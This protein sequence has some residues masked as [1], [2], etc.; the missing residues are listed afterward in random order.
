MIINSASDAVKLIEFQKLQVQK[1]QKETDFFAATIS[2]LQSL[3]I[4]FQ[5]FSSPHVK[6]LLFHEITRDLSCPIKSHVNQPCEIS[7]QCVQ[8]A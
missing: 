8:S 1:V 4:P 3:S 2:I 5:E 6:S 7:P